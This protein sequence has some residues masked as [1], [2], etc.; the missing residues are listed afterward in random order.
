VL[1]AKIDM[2]SANL[3]LRAPVIYRILNASHPRTGAAWHIY[4]SYDFAHGQYVEQDDFHEVPPH[5]FRRLALGRQVRFRYTY[6]VTCHDVVKDAI[7]RVVELRYAYD[8]DSRGGAGGRTVGATIH[9]VSAVDAL[10]AEVGLYGRLFSAASP[11]DLAADLDPHHMQ[12]LTGCLVELATAS[13]PNG[14][15]FSK[16]NCESERTGSSI[17]PM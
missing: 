11:T 3:N 14:Q 9:W 7:G 16:A 13:D 2:A 10:P 8:P 5:D 6:R 4:P 12:T 1:R 17:F 15:V